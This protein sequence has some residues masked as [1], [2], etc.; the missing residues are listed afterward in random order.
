M[1]APLA[2]VGGL[3]EGSLLALLAG[4]AAVAAWTWSQSVLHARYSG[5]RLPLKYFWLPALVPWVGAALSLSLKVWPR[6]DWRGRRYRLSNG[7]AGNGL[8][9]TPTGL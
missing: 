5:H 8:K 2:A 3:V 4:F 1:V 9:L 6:I 7:G